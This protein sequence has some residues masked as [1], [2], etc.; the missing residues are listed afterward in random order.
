MGLDV[1]DGD[2][3]R[4]VVGSKERDA[5]GGSMMVGD[6]VGTGVLVHVRLGDTDGLSSSD[7][8]SERVEEREGL[9]SKLSDGDRVGVGVHPMR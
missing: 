5:E 7:S 6:G 3:V 1:L 9:P 8:S 2:G 4:V